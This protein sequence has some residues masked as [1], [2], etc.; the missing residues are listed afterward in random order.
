VKRIGFDRALALTLLVLALLITVVL[1]M[2]APS[3][4]DVADS[5]ESREPDGRLALALVLARAGFEP[6][7]WRAAPGRLPAGP[8][9][10]WAAHAPRPFGAHFEGASRR[11]DED[12]EQS[13]ED[14]ERSDEREET[15][16]EAHAVLARRLGP[17]ALALHDLAH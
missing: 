13:D 7:A 15:R 10:V 2:F 3:S 17:G 1:P 8:H 9:V 5:I 11:G 16:E 12:P 6:E 4:D 14:P